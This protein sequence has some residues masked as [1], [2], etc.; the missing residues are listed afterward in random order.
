MSVHVHM[1][2]VSTLVHDHPSIYM[3][4]HDAVPTHKWLARQYNTQFY[5]ISC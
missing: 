1:G 4:I 2:D 5:K 3:V